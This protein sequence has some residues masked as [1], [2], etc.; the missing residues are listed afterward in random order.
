MPKSKYTY[1]YPKADIT[2][3]CVLF[4]LTPDWRLEVVLIKRAEDP[5]KGKWALPGGFIEFL[6]GET[7]YEAARREMQEETGIEVAY[8]EQLGTFDAPERD[9]RGRVFSVAHYALV[10]TQDHK[11]EAGSDASR[12]EWVDVW[13]A[14]SFGKDSVAFDHALILRTAV[15]RLQAK[16]RYAPVGFNLLPE[17][18]T[19]EQLRKVYQ[20]ILG[21]ATPDKP[22]P[23]PSNFRKK[24]RVLN[25][26]AGFLEETGTV[27]ERR[28]GGAARLYR[29]NKEAYDRATRRGI[30]FEL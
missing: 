2:V 22:Y 20:A 1:D 18:F 9:P 4:G 15:Q 7:S 27:K 28:T 14:L 11:P 24:L 6:K 19:L 13:E 17:T 26:K 29:F 23:E 10:R 16:I 30:N 3:D 21:K 25:K 12:A 5:F 8:L